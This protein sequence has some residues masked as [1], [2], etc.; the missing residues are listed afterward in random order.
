MTGQLLNRE[1]RKSPY[2]LWGTRTD[3]GIPIT[4]A[5]FQK[6]AEEYTVKNYLELE[7]VKDEYE[8]VNM[9]EGQQ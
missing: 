6:Y 5:D 7:N 9:L 4:F 8:I 2:S 1:T 3:D